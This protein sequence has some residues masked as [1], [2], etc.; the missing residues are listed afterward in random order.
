MGC[1]FSVAYGASARDNYCKVTGY[2]EMYMQ[3]E[4]E[5]NNRS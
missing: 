5:N 4:L 3:Y 1:S 2:G